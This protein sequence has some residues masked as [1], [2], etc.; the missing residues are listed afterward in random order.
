M[1]ILANYLHIIG[2]TVW[3]GGM[4][5]AYLC[6]RP[7]AASVLPPAERLRLWCG[8]FGKFFPWVW[9]AVLL[10]LT[11]G[12]S[13]MA[14]LGKPPVHVSLMAALGLLMMLIFAYVFFAPFR[15]LKHAV[16]AEDW[17]VGGAALAQIRQ[18]VGINLL[19]GL[20]VLSVGALGP[21]LG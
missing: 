20:V 14:T 17:S 16:A 12:L 2:F 19:L 15:R 11:S 5:F 18:L 1:I 10:L 21:L 8:V 6:L 3:I 13:M 4:F 9:L 7:V